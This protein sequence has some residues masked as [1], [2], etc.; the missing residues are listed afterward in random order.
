MDINAFRA[1]FQLKNDLVVGTDVESGINAFVLNID[2]ETTYID[3][4]KWSIN[5]AQ[6]SMAN[7]QWY[8]IDGRQLRGKPTQKG[9]YI[10]N[11]QKVVLK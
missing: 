7:D 4:V 3:N 10:H 2:G 6:S 11:K 1:Y 9:I 5:D 8:T